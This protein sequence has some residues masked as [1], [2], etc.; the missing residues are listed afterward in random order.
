[1]AFLS[2]TEA[3]TIAFIAL[4]V[5]LYRVI[6]LLTNVSSPVTYTIEATQWGYQLSVDGPWAEEE[7]AGD[8]EQPEADELQTP[9]AQP[10]MVNAPFGLVHGP[11]A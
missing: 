2:I 7:D 11:N 4:L 10:A 3:L 6:Q 1:M 8:E 9:V 5:F